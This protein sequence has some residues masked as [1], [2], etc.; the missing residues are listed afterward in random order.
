MARLETVSSVA[1]KQRRRFLSPAL[2]YPFRI[3]KLGKSGPDTGRN[4]SDSGYR[5]LDEKKKVSTSAWHA[6][7]LGFDPPVAYTELI[8][9]GVSKTR[10]FKWLVKVGASKAYSSK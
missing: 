7:V 4:Q 2:I 10:K 5:G 6:A 9:G 3:F 1:V 8:S